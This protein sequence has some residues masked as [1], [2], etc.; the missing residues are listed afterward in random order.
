[1]ITWR[2]KGFKEFMWWSCFTYDKKGPYHIWQQ[3]TKAKKE[4][5]KRDLD[6]RN[7]ARYKKDKADWEMDRIANTMATLLLGKAPET[8]EFKH[9]ESTGAYISSVAEE[10]LIGTIIKRLFS[11]LSFFPLLKS[12]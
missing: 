3:E 4:A 12:V 6:A 11:S 1:V 5:C 9:D 7:V 8:T 2:W 10:V